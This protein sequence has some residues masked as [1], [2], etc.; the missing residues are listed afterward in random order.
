MIPALPG[1]SWIEVLRDES[2]VGL[3]VTMTPTWNETAAFADHVLPMGLSPERHDVQS[4]ETHA[5]RWI[6][7]RQPVLKVAKERLGE[8]FD[9]TYEANPGEVWE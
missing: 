9:R 2:K 8:R 1:A 7:F 5:G 4:Q 3:H 6:G